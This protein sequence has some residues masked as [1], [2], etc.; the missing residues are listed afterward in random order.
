[1]N[2]YEALIQKG[3]KIVFEIGFI[4]GMGKSTKEIAIRMNKNGFDISSISLAL[5]ISK[6]EVEKILQSGKLPEVDFLRN[7]PYQSS[8]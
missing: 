6:E 1:M 3:E 8:I 2:T 5:D 7:K 4:A